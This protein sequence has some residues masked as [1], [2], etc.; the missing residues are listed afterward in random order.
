MGSG[1]THDPEKQR[2]AEI[3]TRLKDLYGA[4]ASDD[5]KLHFANGIV[6]CVLSS[7]LRK[8]LIMADH[9]P[10]RTCRQRKHARSS[11][12]C[13]WNDNWYYTAKLYLIFLIFRRLGVHMARGITRMN[14]PARSSQ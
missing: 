9:D 1:K 5:D 3:I 13:G 12:L 11:V 6:T 10:K 8:R 7:K 4:E 14:V 2:L